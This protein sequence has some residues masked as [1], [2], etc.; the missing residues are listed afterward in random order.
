VTNENYEEAMRV[1]CL[2]CGITLSDDDISTC[3]RIALSSGIEVASDDKE[4]LVALEYRPYQ[5]PEV[6]HFRPMAAVKAVAS[7]AEGVA[8]FQFNH[9]EFAPF[10]V[11]HLI[12]ALA[13]LREPLGNAEA[14]LFYIVFKQNQTGDVTIP[15]CKRDFEERRNRFPERSAV[16]F[17]DVL[18]RLVDAG[19]VEQMGE[20]L[21]LRERV[22]LRTRLPLFE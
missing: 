1:A 5:H 9:P 17:E 10:A 20:N 19:L 18:E 14:D 15:E 3:S 21:T 16:I 7:F 4:H 22:I 2:A 11:V 8:S 6:T 12:T 13:E